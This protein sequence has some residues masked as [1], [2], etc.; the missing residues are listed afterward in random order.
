M[1]LKKKNQTK[2]LRCCEQSADSWV[3]EEL[4]TPAPESAGVEVSSVLWTSF[5]KWRC[6]S[7]PRWALELILCRQEL[8]SINRTTER[9]GWALTSKETTCFSFSKS[10]R[11]SWLESSL[12]VKK[13]VMPKLPIGLFAGIHLG[14]AAHVCTWEDPEISPTQTLNQPNQHDWPRE[15]QK[16]CPT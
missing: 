14:W 11:P 12:E 10:G 5:R 7:H 13:G 15:S 3:E 4:Q 2:Q 16:I 8:Q 9:G 1:R 6:P